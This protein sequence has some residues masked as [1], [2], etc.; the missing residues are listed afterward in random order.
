MLKKQSTADGLCICCLRPLDIDGVSCNPDCIFKAPTKMKIQL[1]MPLPPSPL[2]P[3]PLWQL[4][5]DQQ[6]VSGRT[7]DHCED[8]HSSR[9]APGELG[10]GRAEG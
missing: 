6:L 5:G 10:G 3:L 1:R 8:K 4:A 9:H 7:V 2:P